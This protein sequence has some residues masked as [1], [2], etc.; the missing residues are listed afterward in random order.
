[1]SNRRSPGRGWL[2]PFVVIECSLLP[3]IILI[4][5]AFGLA[6]SD[7]ALFAV[8]VLNYHALNLSAGAKPV[9]ESL[10]RLGLLGYMFTDAY[11]DDK[12]K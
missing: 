2:F 7:K 6:V 3:P 1:M 11:S 12:D 9:T 8:V 5:S 10:A 4:A